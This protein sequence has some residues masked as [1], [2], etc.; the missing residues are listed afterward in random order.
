MFDA[1]ECMFLYL[2][3]SLRVGSDEDTVEADLPIQREA[4]TGYP[5]VPGSSLKGALR[6]RAQKQ[7]APV[8][9]LRLL[10]SPP[11]AEDQEPQPSSVV[12]SDAIPLLFPVR[13]LT[14]LFAWVTSIET[15]SRF[16]RDLAAYGVKVPQGPHLPAF[17]AETAAIAPEAPLLCSKRTLVF[18]EL[19]FPVQA[20]EEVAALGAWLAEYAFSDDPVYDFWRTRAARG[21]VVLPEG[22]Y[23]YFVLHGTQV[24][25]RIRID[26]RTGTASDGSLWTEEYLPPET[27]LYGLIG[28]RM[29]EPPPKEIKKASDLTDWV[30]GLAP[31]LLQLGSG[32]TLGHGLVRIRWTGKKLARAGRGS[33]TKKR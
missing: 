14:G 26:P 31:G 23:R 20:A 29:P 8:E 4:A 33:R 9:L 1:S 3:S 32:R 10:G 7:Q 27:L 21:V 25:P 12:V 28:A 13:S 22:A 11:E 24:A 18:E 2:E 6:A 30:R 15:W 5:L 19:S 17:P 16:Q